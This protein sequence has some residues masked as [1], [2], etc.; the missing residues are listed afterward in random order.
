MSQLKVVALDLDGL[1]HLL[2]VA[3]EI[4]G[5]LAVLGHKH[6]T[7]LHQVEDRGCLEL[8]SLVQDCGQAAGDGEGLVR[9]S[10]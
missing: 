3:K 7:L 9:G 1:L 6:G 8:E 4:P 5:P 10:L 2:V